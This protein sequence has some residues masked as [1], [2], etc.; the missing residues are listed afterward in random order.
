MA[1]RP[2]HVNALPSVQLN[3]LVHGDIRLTENAAKSAAL[4]IARVIGNHHA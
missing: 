1:V 2:H 4:H 3:Q